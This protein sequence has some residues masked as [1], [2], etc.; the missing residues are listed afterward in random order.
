MEIVCRIA[1]DRGMS[2]ESY[3]ELVGVEDEVVGRRR[4]RSVT[5]E[6]EGLER[7]IADIVNNTRW[8]DRHVDKGEKGIWGGVKGH[9]NHQ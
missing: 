5:R 7:M 2:E 9:P 6:G 3:V 4:D 1:R 8:P